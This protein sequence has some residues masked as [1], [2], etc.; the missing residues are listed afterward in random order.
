MYGSQ[1]DIVDGLLRA[2]LEFAG[3]EPMADDVCIVGMEVTTRAPGEEAPVTGG[4]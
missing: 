1:Q 3:D 2:V 4:E